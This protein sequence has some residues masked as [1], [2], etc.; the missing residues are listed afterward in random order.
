MKLEKQLEFSFE[1][2]PK[3]ET[4]LQDYEPKTSRLGRTLLWT[5]ITLGVLTLGGVTYYNSMSNKPSQIQKTVQ[6]APKVEE[7]KASVE[8][9]QSDVLETIGNWIQR[10]VKLKETKNSLE[11]SIKMNLVYAAIINEN[12]EKLSDSWNFDEFRKIPEAQRKLSSLSEERIRAYA[13]IWNKNEA[14]ARLLI[15]ASFKDSDKQ[16]FLLKSELKD[17]FNVVFCPVNVNGVSLDDYNL[18]DNDKLKESYQNIFPWIDDF[19]KISDPNKYPEYFPER[20]VMINHAA[21]K[22][23]LKE[24]DKKETLSKIIDSCRFST[25]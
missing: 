22:P 6:Y 21:F 15:Y 11:N 1:E 18:K 4:S 8:K 13:E 17:F 20:M 3:V 2:E 5:G 23:I 24:S 12:K 7:K 9:K 16:R 25:K 10:G 19:K 14:P